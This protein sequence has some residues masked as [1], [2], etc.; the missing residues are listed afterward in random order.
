MRSL[1]I[2]V[3]LLLFVFVAGANADDTA[4]PAENVKGKHLKVK[5]AA[6]VNAPN[7]VHEVWGRTHR[8]DGFVY[9]P[10]Y[11]STGMTVVDIDL[12]ND[13]DFVV[14]GNV[15]T[16]GK[17]QLL[18]NLGASGAFYPG[19]LESLDIQGTPDGVTAGLSMDFEDV[20]HDGLPDLVSEIYLPNGDSAIAWF[21]NIGP[22]KQPSFQFVEILH[23]T[24]RYIW[25]DWAD[26]DNDDLVELFFVEAFLNEPSRHHRVFIVENTGTITEPIWDGA[27]AQEI[28][29][30][31]NLLPDGFV[32]SSLKTDTNE[33]L[34]GEHRTKRASAAEAKADLRYAVS[35]FQM[36]D[37]NADG[38][39]DFMFYNKLEGVHWIPNLDPTF[40]STQPVWEGTYL[41][42]EGN[43]LYDHRED[44][45][46]IKD[47]T[48][49]LRPNPDPVRARTEW[50]DE[51]YI[52]VGGWLMTWRYFI[53]TDETGAK[54]DTKDFIDNST[55]RLIQEN[56]LSY[57]AGKGSIAFWDYDG[58]GDKDMFRSG[59]GGGTGFSYLLLFPNI[60]TPYA[61]AW[62]QF[63]ALNDTVSDLLLSVGSETNKFRYDLFTFADHNASGS[64]DLFVQ[65]QDGR[66]SMYFAFPAFDSSSLPFLYLSVADYGAMIPPGYTNVQPRGL[67]VANFDPNDGAQQQEVI[68]VYS[69]DQG[70]AIAYYDPA[71]SY[72]NTDIS[73]YFPDVDLDTMQEIPDSSLRAFLIEGVCA[74]DV[75]GDGRPDLIVTLAGKSTFSDATH[76]FFRNIPADNILNFEFQFVG[77][78]Q[79]PLDTDPFY[80]RTISATDIDAD[81]DQDIF[82]DYQRGATNPWNYLRF[83]RNNTDTGLKFWRTRVVTGQSWYLWVGGILPS[84]TSVLNS[85]GGNTEGLLSGFYNAGETTNV[86]DIIDSSNDYRVFIDVLPIVEENESKAIIVVGGDPA[87]SLYPTFLELASFSYLV[88]RNEGIPASNILFFANATLDVDSDGLNDVAGPPQLSTLADAASTWAALAEDK[89]LVYFIDHGKRNAFRLNETEYLDASTY[90]NWIN[91]LQ[92]GGLGPQ[93]TTVIDMCEAGS[94]LDDLAISK[95]DKKAGAQRITITSSNIGPVEG[96][97]LFDSRQNISFSLSFWRAIFNGKTYGDAFDTAKVSIESVNPL[98]VPQIDDDGDG[99]GNEANDGLLAKSAR[100]GADFE[101]TLPGVFIGRIKPDTAISTNSA[102]LWLKDVITSF[103]V[104][105]AG[106]LIVPPNF[107]RA[108]LTSDDEQPVTGLEWVDFTF[109]QASDRWEAP[110]SG[111]TVGGLYRV[112]YYVKAGG[113]YHPSPRIGFVDRVGTADAWEDD[114]TPQSAQWMPIN[115][116]QGHN[117]H[118]PGDVDWVQF[119]SPPNQEATIAVLA[120]GPKCRPKVE[121]YSRAGLIENP[122]APPLSQAT[123]RAAGKDVTFTY[124][125]TTTEPH[126]LKISNSHTSP[127]TD[128]EGTS[129]MAMV[130]VGT[131]GGEDLLP[132]TLIVVVLDSSSG[133]GIGEATVEVTGPGAPFS[134]ET[135]VEGIAHFTCISDTNYD[136]AASKAGYQA[137]AT[138]ILVNN[139]LETILI[140]LDAGSQSAPTADFSADTTSGAAPLAVSFTDQSTGS[141]T[142]W[143]W[144]FDNDGSTDS[145]DQNPSHEYTDPGTYT[146]KLTSTNLTGSD[147]ETKT[148]YITVTDGAVAPTADFSADTTSG[149]APLTVSFTDLSTNSPTSWAWDF[150]NDG[151]TDSTDQNPSHAYTATGTYTVKLTATNSAGSDTET[152]TDYITATESTGSAD[153]NGDGAINATDVQLV[154]NAALGI[155][156]PFDA[157]V[158]NDGAVNATDVQL[159]INAALGVD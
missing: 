86:V 121:L 139:Q 114:D 69:S 137:G 76:Y 126:F 66:V 119:S 50:L 9:G 1:A 54:S 92:A 61:P 5:A 33:G 127:S 58:D 49:A 7:F 136:V 13:N 130:A 88:L 28:V 10:S 97:A 47:G 44:G 11:R 73:A 36:A 152:K 81:G 12:D 135:T 113:Q 103:P 98:Q 56:S 142:S 140:N 67:A 96:V 129:Y 21:K 46:V 149:A 77:P 18:R 141:P 37:W 106:A 26:I 63:L 70:S 110:Y 45:F 72:L 150:D 32:K 159:V 133:S 68:A 39:K 131:G 146:V 82:I 78:I 74:T 101:V 62:G 117:F 100:P 31:S 15:T 115:S 155:D 84:Y 35:E 102:T 14:P 53:P 71:Y 57:S 112:L 153:I 116:V 4:V 104:E 23:T 143:A 29:E 105:E 48:F 156:I 91:T 111:F 83:Y 134:G 109:N 151:S 128:G 89:L 147:T 145:T 30:I 42:S 16:G 158:N 25:V 138:S 108:S 87:D 22:V 20:T 3:G 19:G 123:S 75:D 8:G 120:Q 27:S 64:P 59:T 38:D 154:I 2:I 24:P 107:Q 94:F 79:A 43:P 124:T 125:F 144:D 51:F 93:V 6:K 34:A 157:D 90:G 99:I 55:Y 122:E 65:G 148:D 41:E 60:G 40:E 118:T 95:S 17:P 80:G 52:S 85:S 132:A